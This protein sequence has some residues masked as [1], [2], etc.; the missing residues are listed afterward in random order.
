[1]LPLIAYSRPPL[2][3]HLREAVQAGVRPDI[4]EWAEEEVSGGPAGLKGVVAAY[5]QL[6][7]QC[8]HHDPEQR[9]TFPDAIYPQLTALLQECP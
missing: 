7:R 8:W 1:M 4:D 5:C 3:G 9:P 2:P 6:A